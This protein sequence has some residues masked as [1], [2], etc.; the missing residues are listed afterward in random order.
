MR[1][2]CGAE[3][4]PHV[5]ILLVEFSQRDLAVTVKPRQSFMFHSSVA[6]QCATSHS[7]SCLLL[8]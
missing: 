7:Y 2:Q 6:A 8:R 3:S 4:H 1:L 5:E